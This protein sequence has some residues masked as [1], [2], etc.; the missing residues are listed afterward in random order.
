M[1][2]MGPLRQGT[3]RTL[4]DAEPGEIRAWKEALQGFARQASISD[5]H[6]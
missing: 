6:S 4:T 5:A 1:P 3:V 2:Q